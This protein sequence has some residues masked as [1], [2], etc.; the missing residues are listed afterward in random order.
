MRTIF[1]HVGEKIDENFQPN[2]VHKIARLYQLLQFELKL[3][4]SKKTI[5][6]KIVQYFLNLQ[7][8]Y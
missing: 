7:N 8:H 5:F 2:S 4:L 1:D 3:F 6:A